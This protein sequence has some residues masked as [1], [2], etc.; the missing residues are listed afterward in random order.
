MT[1]G[2]MMNL[3]GAV[4][5]VVAT[6]TAICAVAIAVSHAFGVVRGIRGSAEW[7]VNLIPWIAPALPG[8]LDP[9]GQLHRAKMVRW[10]LIA[11]FAVIVAVGAELLA[12][13]S[14]A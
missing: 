3:I 2:V 12:T 13:N 7:W 9:A 4:V 1:L 5:G 8:A 11:V 14:A 10:A 6:M